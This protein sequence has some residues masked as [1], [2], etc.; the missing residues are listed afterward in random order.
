MSVYTEKIT[1]QNSNHDDIC[2][3][4]TNCASLVDTHPVRNLSSRYSKTHGSTTLLIALNV[5]I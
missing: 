5:A 3:V 1:S 4:A 2:A